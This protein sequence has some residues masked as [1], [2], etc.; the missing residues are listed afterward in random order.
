MINN[1]FFSILDRI[2]YAGLKFLVIV[3][4]GHWLGSSGQGTF[5]LYLVVWAWVGTFSSLGLVIS[6]N[7]YGAKGTS[8]KKD[9]PFAWELQSFFGFCKWDARGCS[10]MD[11]GNKFKMFFKGVFPPNKL[12][13]L[14]DR[15]LVVLAVYAI[16][17]V[18][19]RIGRI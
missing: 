2:L 15:R 18:V 5:S 13:I 7:Y 17:G 9:F 11:P 8:P 14:F 1:S 12:H 4:L 6:N 16:T 10:H 3:L 19:G